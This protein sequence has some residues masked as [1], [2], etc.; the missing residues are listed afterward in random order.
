[1]QLIAEAAG[2]RQFLAY[3]DRIGLDERALNLGE[4]DPALRKSNAP[5]A[6]AAQLAV[7]LMEAA[8]EFLQRPDLGVHF[9]EWLDP[10]GFGPMALLGENCMTFADRFRLARRF[11]HLQNNALSFEQVRE[12]DDVVV[13]CAVHPTLRPRARQFTEAIVAQSVR[14]ARSLL[15]AGWN[16]VRIEFAHAPPPSSLTQKRYFRC[17]IQ[18]LSDRDAFV[19]SHT[20]FH[21]RLPKGDPETIAFLE[22]HLASQ[23]NRW[24]TDLRGQVENLIASQLAGGG[25]SLARIAALLALSPRT[26]QRRLADQGEDFGKILTFV[27]VQIARN[28]L[29]QKPPPPLAKLCHLLGYSEPSAASRFIKTQMGKTARTIVRE[30]NAVRRPGRAHGHPSA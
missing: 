29:A 2:A 14:N 12:G 10:H 9:A 6:I 13:L 21:R 7:D 5:M 1:V 4:I 27:R 18:Y 22:K 20:D 24:P 11:V 19:V 30:S 25:V 17:P 3:L 8:S 16:P 23:E 28:Y 15:G 26:L